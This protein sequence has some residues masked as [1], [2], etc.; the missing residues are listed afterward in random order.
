MGAGFSAG[1]S[2]AGSSATTSFA[3]VGGSASGGFDPIPTL[4]LNIYATPTTTIDGAAVPDT[5]RLLNGSEYQVES[6][7]S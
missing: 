2:A 7:V 6:A 3:S 5:A 4:T 1:A